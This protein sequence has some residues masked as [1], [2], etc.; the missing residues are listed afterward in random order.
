ME[1]RLAAIML[2][3]I[4]GYSGLIALDEEGTIARQKSQRDEI[5]EPKITEHGGRVVKT[6]GDGLLVEFESVVDAVRCAVAVQTELAGLNT[7]VP[8]NRRIQYRIGINLGDIVIDGDDILG[9]GVNVAARLEALAKP[10]GICISSAVY[11]QLAGKMDM[12]FEDAG[13]QKVKNAPRPVRVWQWQTDP[14]SHPSPIADEPLSLPDKPSIAVLPFE[15]L[16][17]DPDQEFLCGAASRGPLFCP[18]RQPASH[19]ARRSGSSLIR[20]SARRFSSIRALSCDDSVDVSA[21]GCADV[22]RSMAVGGGNRCDRDRRIGRSASE[23]G[24]S[25]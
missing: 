1:R 6:T 4:V 22:G 14:T 12:A 10:G 21:A 19:R 20:K 8:E 18:R 17:S 11:D 16:T 2:T 23:S 15:N 9:D 3:D 25:S 24:A 5:I 13:E 7:D